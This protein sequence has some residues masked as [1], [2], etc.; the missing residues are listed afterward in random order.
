MKK[1][2]R[3]ILAC[4]RGKKKEVEYIDCQCG[5]LQCMHQKG[6]GACYETTSELGE[7]F[8]SC[9]CQK[10]IRRNGGRGKDGFPTP[11]PQDLERMIK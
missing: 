11:S 5:H 1:L 4:F 8:R 9:R 10:F 3:W 7:A 6:K 2:I